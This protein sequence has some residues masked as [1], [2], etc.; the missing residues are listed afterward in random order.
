MALRSEIRLSD[1][2][3]MS[4]LNT[5]IP[6]SSYG[7]NKRFK[8]FTRADIIRYLDHFRKDENGDP[9]HRDWDLQR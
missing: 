2:Y 8:D 6:L 7:N 4:I 5:L 9:A 3:R 1:N